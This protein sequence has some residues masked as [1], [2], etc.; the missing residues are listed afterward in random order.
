M[1][2][3]DTPADVD[4]DQ[5]QLGGKENSRFQTLMERGLEDTHTLD[6]EVVREK[7]QEYSDELRVAAQIARAQFDQPFGGLNPR[8][9][10]F[11]ASRIHSGYFGWDSWENLGALT[12]GTTTAWIDDG[13]PDNL[14]GSTGINEP[15]KVGE[16]AV[17]AVLGFGSYHDSPK[18]SAIEYEVNRQPRSAVRVKYEW[19]KT[20]VQIKWL[21]RP[22]ILPENALLAAQVYADTAGDDFP[23]L[24]GVSYIKSRASQEPDPA[25]MT[26]DSQDTSDNIVAQG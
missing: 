25:N 20:D 16:E 6:T 2:Q 13:T 7:I 24:F 15:L 8:E 3:V 21:D 1:P 5:E 4:T 12:A 19:T 10:Q 26:D 9:G 23:Y 22:L 18:V 17:H 14:G 11:A